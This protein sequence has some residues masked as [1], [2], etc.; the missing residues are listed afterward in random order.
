V[1][2]L[3]LDYFLFFTNTVV[4]RATFLQLYSYLFLPKLLQLFPS[5]SMWL[6][7]VNMSSEVLMAD[8]GSQKPRL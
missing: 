6:F 1:F 5:T 4:G 3:F 2:F 8:I 7:R